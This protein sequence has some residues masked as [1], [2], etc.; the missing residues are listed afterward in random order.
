[1]PIA[2]RMSLNFKPSKVFY[3]WWI[4]GACFLIAM[5]TSGALFHGFTAIFKP[6]TNEFGWSYTQISF[7]Q[8]I[9]GL[10][11]S[12]VAP[13]VGILVDRWGPRKLIFGGVCITSIGLLLLS[14]TNSLSVFYI[15]AV[16]TAIGMSSSGTWVTMAAVGSWFRRK[17]GL[18]TGIMVCGYGAGGFL[19]PVMVKLI[20]TYEWRTTMVILA[21]GILIIGLPLSLMVRHKPEQY[22]YLPDG[23][24]PSTTIP[25]VEVAAIPDPK[26]DTEV[27]RAL[28]S[29]VFWHLTLALTPQ[30]IAIGAVITH[31]MPYLSSLGITRSVSGLVAMAIPLMSISGRFGFCWLSDIFDK[32]RRS[33]DALA[34][35]ALG[36]LC[37]EYI[38]AGGTWLLVPAIIFLGIGYGGNIPIMALLVREYFGRNKFGTI[39]GFVWGI[40]ML[41]NVTGPPISGWVFDNWGN[42]QGIWLAFAGLTAIGIFIMLN[43]PT[44]KAWSRKTD[45]TP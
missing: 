19:V 7:A 37:F 15:A 17:M 5:Y 23:E 18:A 39:I 26:A 10:E 4:V 29:R 11:V 14:R 22:G 45:R 28:K 2:P 20:D 30:F 1:M 3:G 36:L 44:V 24:L 21:I 16:L 9:R 12:L 34:I 13:L 25:E 41:G 8:S 38:P 33:A 32:R 42:Y 35:L 40:L 6:I 43:T 31:V 27:K